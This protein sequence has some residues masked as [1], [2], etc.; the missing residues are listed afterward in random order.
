MANKSR[1]YNRSA[2]ELMPTLIWAAEQ[3]GRF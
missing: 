2:A 1:D 3:M